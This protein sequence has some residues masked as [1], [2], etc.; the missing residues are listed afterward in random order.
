MTDYDNGVR[1]DA[2]A[3]ATWV[4]ATASDAYNDC[5]EIARL[6]RGEVAV[7]NS[8][9]PEGPALIFTSSELAA[10]LD[11]ARNGEFDGMVG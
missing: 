11:G 9:F 4:K 3:G 7:R 10:F 5:V 1:A 2:I 6:S 8:R